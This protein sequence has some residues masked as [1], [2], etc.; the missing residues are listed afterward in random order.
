MDIIAISFWTVSNINSQYMAHY[1]FRNRITRI[2]ACWNRS[3]LMFLITFSVG[4]ALVKQHNSECR[5]FILFLSHNDSQPFLFKSDF[6]C[7]NC[8]WFSFLKLDVWWV[9]GKWIKPWVELTFVVRFKFQVGKN[10]ECARTWL[11]FWR[12]NLIFTQRMVDV[13]FH[14]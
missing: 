2:W 4:L 14:T 12:N 11:I 7:K 9:I 1:C 6:L 3:T 5:N 8:W 10:V 13:C